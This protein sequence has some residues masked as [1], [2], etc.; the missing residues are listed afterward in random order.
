M[1][2]KLIVLYASTSAL[3][4]FLLFLLEPMCSRA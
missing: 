4:A 1:S 2:S 3:G